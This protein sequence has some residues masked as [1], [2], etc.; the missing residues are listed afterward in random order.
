METDKRSTAYR[1]SGRC[2]G[3]HVVIACT[4]ISLIMANGSDHGVVIETGG[5]FDH[6]FRI[7]NSRNRRFN[8]GEFATILQWRI[9]FGIKCFKMRRT[10]IHPDQDTALCFRDWSTSCLL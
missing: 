2:T 8:V 7:D 9:G 3:R 6:V 10:T 1:N 4:V 5:Q